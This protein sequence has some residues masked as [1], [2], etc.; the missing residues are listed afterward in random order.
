MVVF[1]LAKYRKSN[2]YTAVISS[3]GPVMNKLRAVVAFFL[4]FSAGSLQASTVSVVA[5]GDSLVDGGNLDLALKSQGGTGLPAI[6]PDGQFTNGDTWATQ[7]G[8]APSLTGG[9]NFAYG[10]ARAISNKDGIPDLKDQIKAFR[11]SGFVADAFTT[12]VIWIG[13]NDFLALGPDASEKS[14][15]RTARKVTRQISRAALQLNQSG[16]SDVVVLGLPEF[17]SLPGAID[18]YNQRLGQKISFLDRVL[19][20]SDFSFFDVNGLY[21][22]VAT[23]V[24][25]SLIDTPCLL[26]P[27]GCAATV[28]SGL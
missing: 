16:I 22:A 12:G 17:G 6:Y 4:I 5:F 13:G 15:L 8:L 27:A 14:F 19:P 28:S 7:L 11:K 21:Q 26:D 23:Q 25:P 20:N 18:V 10:G 3:L 9:T 2:I 24:P 1:P